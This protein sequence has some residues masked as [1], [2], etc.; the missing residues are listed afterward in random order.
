MGKKGN[1]N[2]ILESSGF[3]LLDPQ[4]EPDFVLLCWLFLFL[5]F[6]L[7][8]ILYSCVGFSSFSTSFSSRTSSEKALGLALIQLSKQRTD[9]HSLS[10]SKNKISIG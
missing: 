6:F 4:R 2:N 8:L 1:K 7:F 3:G 9:A 5:H 10:P